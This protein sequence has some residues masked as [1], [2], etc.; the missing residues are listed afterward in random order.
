[1]ANYID[2]LQKRP[3][4]AR[5]R[6]AFFVSFFITII[7]FGVW[8]SIFYIRVQSPEESKEASSINSPLTAVKQN[9]IDAYHGIIAQMADFRGALKAVVSAVQGH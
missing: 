6:I 3:V 1:M 9:S 4:R 5:H 2:Q 7:I 8:L